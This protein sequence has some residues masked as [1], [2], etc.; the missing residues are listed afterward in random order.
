MSVLRVA[1]NWPFC[2]RRWLDPRVPYE[3]SI[4]E[5]NYSALCAAL[6]SFRACPK[7]RFIENVKDTVAPWSELTE[8]TSRNGG[9]HPRSSSGEP[10]APTR[11]RDPCRHAPPTTPSPGRH[12][13]SAPRRPA[14]GRK[15]RGTTPLAGRL[16][17]LGPRLPPLHQPSRP[18]RSASATR[19]AE[20]TRTGAGS[21]SRPAGRPGRRRRRGRRACPA[22]HRP[23]TR[24]EP[25]RPAGV[26]S[27]ALLLARA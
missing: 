8:G 21:G 4:L 5:M 23:G 9:S 11:A 26:E 6:P 17:P 12:P 24:P 13:S 18:S 15:G 22:A 7:E 10:C 16:R 27:V 14:F 3:R 25:A 19:T 1:G 20:R 2:N